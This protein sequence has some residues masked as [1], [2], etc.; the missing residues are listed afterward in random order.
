[1]K[2]RY[3]LG[4]LTIVSTVVSFPLQA[5]TVAV[6]D[7]GS[8]QV[9]SFAVT[10][11]DSWV[12]SGVLIPSGTYDGGTFTTP[13]G[14]AVS[15]DRLFV[16][17]AVAGGRILEFTKTGSFVKTVYDFGST[18]TPR[19]IT[20]GPDGSL[21]MSD[22]FGSAGDCIWKIDVN[23]NTASIFITTSTGTFA[24]PHG[25]AFASDGNLYVADRDTVGAGTS[26]G[27]IKKFSN[28]GSLLNANVATMTQPMGLIW[29]AS[30]ERLL[31]G[32]GFT[33]ILKSVTL[34]GTQSTLVDD[35]PNAGFMDAAIFNGKIYVS[36]FTT[37][38][39]TAGIYRLT[40]STTS[41]LVTGTNFGTNS[42]GQMVVLPYAGADTDADGLPDPWEIANFIQAGENSVADA[43]AIL[44]RN[45]GNGD[46]DGDGLKNLAEY[47][48]GTNPKL[49]DTDEDGL[50]DNVETATG[51]WV[52]STNTGTKPLK[53]DSDGDGLLD[54]QENKSG[55][56]V[57]PT[58]TG[59]NP[60]VADSDADSFSDYLE[61]ARASNPLSN[62]S[63][64]AGFSATPL[65]DL[66]AAALLDGP[67][68]SW[69]NPGTLG[70]SFE[71]DSPPSVET[72]GG[73]KGVTFTGNE[74]M[75][76][77]VAPSNLTGNSP[78][79]IQAWIFNPG[80][81]T[82]EA[83]VAWGRRDGGNGTSNVFSHG[84]NATFGA[85]GNWGTPDMAWGPDANSIT[86]NVKL[87]SWTYVVYTF[88]G[89]ATN[90]GKV[91]SN[92]IEANTKAL[93][94]LST[95]AVGNTTAARPLP[96]R[97][98]GQN[99]ASGAL[100][101]A[102]V[103]GS[104]TIAKIKIHDRVV[105][106]AELGFNDTDGDGMTDW[107]EDFYGLNKMLNDASSDLDNDGLTNQQEQAGGTSPSLPDSD[108]DGMSDSWEVSNFG[109]QTASP[110][111][112]ADNDGSTNFDEFQATLSI[113]ITRDIDGKVTATS[114]S[115][116]SSNP[117]DPNSQPDS[118]SDGLPDG[119]EFINL[120]G[121]FEGPNDD[122][123]S[124]TYSNLVE[125]TA[126]SNPLN[127]LSIP[128]DTDA[129][130][131]ADAWE[132][133]NFVLIS[134]QNGSGDPDSDG[135]NNEAEETGN[136]NPNDPNSQPDSDLDGLP[137]G[138][139][140]TNFGNLNQDAS[141]DFDGDSFTDLAES[142]AHS[143]P[144]RPGNTP[145]NVHSTVTVAAATGAN[146]DEWSVTDNVWTKTR[147]ISPG[148]M[149]TVTFLNGDF[150]GV[151]GADVV[152]VNPYT[153]ARTVLATRNTGAALSAGWI[154]AGARDIEVGPDGR[155]YFTTSFG[156]GSGQG[157]FCVNPDGSGF[158][159]FIARSGGTA[160]DNWVLDNSIGLVW[161][162]ND[163]YVSA[164]ATI[165][166]AN[167]PIYKFNTSGALVSTL[168]KN[169][170]APMGLCLDGSNIVVG[171]A[172]NG[173][174][175]VS[176]KLADATASYTK[177]GVFSVD[178]INILGELHTVTFSSGLSGRGSVLKVGS[179]A[180][181]T[182]VN[183]DLGATANDLLVFVANN[184]DSDAD[185]LTDA[186]EIT[187]FGNL[188]QTAT[189]DPDA[190]GTSNKAEFA[191]G[192]NP[193]LALS[194]FA[195]S[196]A[197]SAATGITLTWA[198]AEGVS[199]KVRSSTDLADWSVV[200]TTV[201]GQAG[202]STASWVTPPA[203]SG[204]KKFYRIEFTP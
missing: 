19:M 21:Y 29:D 36:R 26:N 50:T 79:T 54:S 89:G 30:G 128:S 5:E 165:S 121:V 157:V 13:W 104:L 176:I 160:P 202:Q 31:V 14:L 112:D 72:L 185:R 133:T 60:N 108:N 200:E 80:A 59:T 167:Q 137:D 111:G 122:S 177:T 181:M 47:T 166:S 44:A 184:P 191:L 51:T 168:V 178:V 91:Y 8:N 63:T 204:G 103:K 48:A 22:A 77:P 73:I 193:K 161:N 113:S 2:T 179:K 125:F 173:T 66:S 109:N 107:Y 135:A 52:S 155:L 154:D 27:R 93:G 134:A 105:S 43:A 131:L 96:I 149:D 189:G 140:I 143:N 56:Y 41:S 98:A 20:L 46:A 188:D 74:V 40:G 183:N 35:L 16:S 102:G 84:T 190:D 129:D 34:S 92:G 11:S 67:L 82:E 106:A 145:A 130:G 158:S 55:V 1:M 4:I 162:G 88:D 18:T 42:S 123:D 116:T 150:Y 95:W 170:T 33:G 182:T 39:A 144:L 86:N 198:S 68:S 25:L 75:T 159:R 118:D 9:E 57:S 156:T 53:A 164:R 146:L 78:R 201:V 6:A 174:A 32:S 127:P 148:I 187:Q 124:D 153:G 163:L 194:R 94:P 49:T 196:S 23:L 151:A 142:I 172:A 90:D 126:G 76:G 120:S 62:T 197:G 24:N 147:T 138:Y 65:V 97:I 10:D 171:G 85:V 119:W 186:W 12:S 99:A 83:I 38:A 136:S 87:G 58:N 15:G 152:K 17:E 199:F 64:P 101:T 37:S 45:D 132:R 114:L 7:P 192:L 69:I 139:E 180:A 100:S 71:A 141:T 115:S 195:I 169:L 175:L 28:T 110:N 81:S 70:R 3:T 61:I 203:T 117:T